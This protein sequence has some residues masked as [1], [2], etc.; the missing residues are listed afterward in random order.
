MQKQNL[1]N[2][3]ILDEFAVNDMIRF[4][5]NYT[6]NTKDSDEI[7]MSDN[8]EWI[9][10]LCLVKKIIWKSSEKICNQQTSNEELVRIKAARYFDDKWDQITN[11]NNASLEARLEK[12]R[13][14]TVEESREKFFSKPRDRYCKKI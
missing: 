7:S 3:K 1:Q 10:Q 2:I 9:Y 12:E 4:S 5:L 6:E 13:K 8:Y 11:N 14:S